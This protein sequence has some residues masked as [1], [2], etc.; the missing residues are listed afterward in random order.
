MPKKSAIRLS[1]AAATAQ[2]S[3]ELRLEDVK[4]PDW[5]QRIFSRVASGQLTLRDARYE[6]DTYVQSR[7]LKK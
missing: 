2:A 7:L 4:M 3:A 1:T 5:G 6:I